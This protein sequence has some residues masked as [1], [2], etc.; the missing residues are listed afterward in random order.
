MPAMKGMLHRLALHG[1]SPKPAEMC[2]KTSCDLSAL[3]FPLL[4]DSERATVA[5]LRK[6]LCSQGLTVLLSGNSNLFRCLGQAGWSW[7]MTNT[8]SS[9][10]FVNGCLLDF[11]S[12]FFQVF[13][14]PSTASTNQRPQ[15]CKCHLKKQEFLEEA[16]KNLL[17]EQSVKHNICF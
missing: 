4:C 2:D 17:F 15:P 1:V 9:R 5:D 8:P 11:C 10:C 6:E 12:C 14:P 13:V 3:D 7:G 16:Q